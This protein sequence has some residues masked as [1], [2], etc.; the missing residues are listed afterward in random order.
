M[1]NENDEVFSN[2]QVSSISKFRKMCSQILR[3][4]IHVFLNKKDNA[5][6]KKTVRILKAIQSL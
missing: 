2:Y 6:L 3:G 1:C 5:E 4:Y